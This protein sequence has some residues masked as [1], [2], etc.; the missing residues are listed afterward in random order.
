MVRGCKSYCCSNQEKA[1]LARMRYPGYPTSP[2]S[3]CPCAVVII[4]LLSAWKRARVIFQVSRTLARESRDL[5]S[6][7]ALPCTLE[8]TLCNCVTS[9]ESLLNESVK[10]SG[11][12][13]QGPTTSSLQADTKLLVMAA[14]C[15]GSVDSQAVWA[16]QETAL[17]LISDV[18]RG[19][20]RSLCDRQATTGSHLRTGHA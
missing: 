15:P 6:G 19:C 16:L 5:N 17:Q 10:G 20:G 8:V 3:C 12:A 7:P 18:C 1:T 13:S 2:F 4:S 9:P 14:R 11:E